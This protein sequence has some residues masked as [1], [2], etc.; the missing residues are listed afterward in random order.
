MEIVEW[1]LR[2]RC[3]R[4]PCGDRL[5]CFMMVVFG[6]V[7]GPSEAMDCHYG[8]A[9]DANGDCRT[10]FLNFSFVVAG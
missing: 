8:L 5:L 10:D 9:R 3:D 2:G 7:A 1:R 6:F 4:R